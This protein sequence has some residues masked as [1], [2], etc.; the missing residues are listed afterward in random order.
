[1]KIGIFSTTDGIRLKMISKLIYIINIFQKIYHK[2]NFF[3][4]ILHILV[5]NYKNKLLVNTIKFNMLINFAS[6]DHLYL[7]YYNL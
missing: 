1:M 6:K 7:I 5:P 2:Y 4:V 3:F